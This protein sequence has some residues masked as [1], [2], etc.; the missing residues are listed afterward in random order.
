METKKKKNVQPSSTTRQIIVNELHKPMRINFPRRHTDIR[1][2]NET[3]Q[4]DLIDMSRYWKV[5]K[6][7]KFILSIIDVFSKFAWAIPLKNKSAIAIHAVLVKFLKN[8]TPHLNVSAVKHIMSDDGGEFFNSKCKTLFTSLGINHYSSFTS[9]KATIVERWNR[10]IKTKIWRHFSMVGNYKW[11]NDLQR[12]VDEYNNTKH[13]T[14]KYS[15]AEV[16]Q[17]NKDQ[18]LR[19]IEASHK[20]TKSKAYKFKIGNYVRIS[21][22][23]Y[24]FSKG[25]TANWSAEIFKIIKQNNSS[26]PTYILQDESGNIINGCFYPQELQVTHFPNTFLI[27]KIIKKDLRRK[28]YLVKWFEIPHA[29]NSWVTEADLIPQHG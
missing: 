19:N 24:A 2:I 9:L 10:T 1:D 21:K 4:M 27:E 7:F 12:L 8:T 5:N 11:I 26:P 20:F 3:L 14:I 22:Q 23:K 16:N 6:G 13:R 17:S 25:Y 18:V 28:L 29:K 15:P